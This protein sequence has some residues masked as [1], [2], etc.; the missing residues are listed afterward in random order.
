MKKNRKLTEYQ[1][2]SV[3]G[4]S[5]VSIF[6]GMLDTIGSRTLRIICNY[7]GSTSLRRHKFL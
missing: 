6:H 7:S 3:K 1:L 4:F 5:A 2:S